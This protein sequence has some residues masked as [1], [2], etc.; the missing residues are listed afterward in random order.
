MGIAKTESSAQITIEK[1]QY[2]PGEEIRVT[3][4]CDNSKCRK[5]IE[6]FKIKI[7]RNLLVFGYNKAYQRHQSYISAFNSEEGCDAKATRQIQL[8]LKVPILEERKL[9]EV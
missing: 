5:P 8:S 3:I 2:F 1:D 6:G 9:N 4:D 7:Q